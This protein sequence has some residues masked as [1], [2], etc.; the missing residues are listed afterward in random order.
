MEIRQEE[1]K[2][3]KQF[4]ESVFSF[5]AKMTVV[6]VFW[7]FNTQ[8]IKQKALLSIPFSPIHY[9]HSDN[10]LMHQLDYRG[11]YH[12]SPE[13]YSFQFLK[14]TFHFVKGIFFV[15]KDFSLP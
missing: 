8:I 5:V 14:S 6:H 12:Y 10:F 7:I 1:E 9:F 2:Q 13:L 15:E 3:I 11:I 4:D